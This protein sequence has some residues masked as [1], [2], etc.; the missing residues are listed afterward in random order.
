MEIAQMSGHSNSSMTFSMKRR[1]IKEKAE[2]TGRY[3]I[4][5]KAIKLPI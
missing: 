4:R 1:Q 3:D 2:R 5:E